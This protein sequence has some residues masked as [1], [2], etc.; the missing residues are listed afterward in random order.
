VKYL[1]ITVCAGF[2]LKCDMDCISRKFYAASNSIFNNTRGACELLQLNMQQVYCLSILQY[3]SASLGLTQT[4]I[5][6]LNVCWNN[7]YRK[8]FGFHRW[9]SVKQFIVGISNLD[10]EFLTY[11]CTIKFIKGMLVSNNAV[12][13]RLV[14]VFCH[15]DECK[16]LLLKLEISLNDSLYVIRKQLY[17]LCSSGL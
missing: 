10:F 16:R 2:K 15:S 12:V 3:G 17:S 1:G 8:I 5:K 13:R 14:T 11:F 6:V 4:Q 9:E 7:V